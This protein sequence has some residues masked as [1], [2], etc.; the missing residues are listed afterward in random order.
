MND[1]QVYWMIIFYAGLLAGCGFV[2]LTFLLAYTHKLHVDEIFSRWWRMIEYK[3]TIFLVGNLI[4]MFY[5][6]HL[7]WLTATPIALG[8]G[9]LLVIGYR[10]HNERN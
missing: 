4:P 10:L 3:G 9:P 5:T 1:T 7:L 8:Y 6:G 2:S